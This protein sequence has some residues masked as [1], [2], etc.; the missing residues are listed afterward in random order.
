MHR[1]CI[2]RRGVEAQKRLEESH[3]V[4]VTCQRL[5]QVRLNCCWNRCR[6]PRIVTENVAV[7]V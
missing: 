1:G 2:V 5:R 7:T 3:V 6:P 4:P